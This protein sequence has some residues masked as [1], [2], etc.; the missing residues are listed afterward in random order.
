MQASAMILALLASIQFSADWKQ[1]K[2]SYPVV[3][4]GEVERKMATTTDGADGIRRECQLKFRRKS[5]LQYF[6]TGVRYP[7][8][9]SS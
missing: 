7:L 4:V 5:I 1:L 3:S 2:T 6:L 8:Y 9:M